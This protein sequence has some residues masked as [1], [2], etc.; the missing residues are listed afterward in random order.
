MKA[1]A[2]LSFLFV[3][4]LFTVSIF[5]QPAEPTLV[6][7]GDG[8]SAIAYPVTI[9]WGDMA[10][11]VTKYKI[12]LSIT[13]GGGAPFLVDQELNY[14][15]D[16]TTD[17]TTITYLPAVVIP[18]NTQVYYQLWSW[19]GVAWSA[20][21]LTYHSFTTRIAQPV[22][23]GP[24]GTA[25]AIHPTAAWTFAGGQTGV[26]FD[27]LYS[28]DGGGT[29]STEISGLAGASVSRVFTHAL[30]YNQ[31]YVVKVTARKGGEAYSNTTSFTTLIA[32]PVITSPNGAGIS[33][34]PTFNWTF[35]G[36]QTG[37]TFDVEYSGDGYV[38]TVSQLGLPGN[39]V[40]QAFFGATLLYNHAYNF[41]ITAHK[42]GDADKVA[43][44][45]FTTLVMPA[46]ALSLPVNA[47]VNQP[48][49][50]TITWAA[51]DGAD[52]YKLSVYSDAACTAELYTT[53]IAG[54]SQQL[55]L[56]T[57]EA[58]TTYYWRVRGVQLGVF[59]NWASAFHFT[60]MPVPISTPINGLTG[61]SVLPTFTWVDKPDET[62][63]TVKVS[64]AGGSQAA[65]DAGVIITKVTLQNAVSYATLA[66]ELNLPL[67]NETMYYWQV[68]VQGGLSNT[69]KSSIYHFTTTPSNVVS[70]S[71]PYDGNVVYGT[72]VNFS[73]FLGLPTNHLQFIVQYKYAAAGPT[74]PEDEAFWSGPTMTTLATTTSLTSPGTILLG[75]T[76]YW[77]VL[78]QR[79]DAPND[80]VYYPMAN[81][82]SSFT[83]AGGATIIVTPS[84]PVG[85][86]TVYT[87]TPTLY[88]YLDMYGSGLVYTVRYSK[89]ADVNGSGML[90][91][92]D[93]V[94]V[95]TSNLYYTFGAALD[96]GVRYYWQLMATYTG[97]NSS[98]AWTTPESFTTQGIGT[99]Q[100]PIPAYPIEGLT[101]YTTSP[102]FHWWLP[103][104]GSGLVYDVDLSTINNF[105][106][107]VAGFPV[108]TLVADQMSYD[109]SGITAGQ[110]YY[111]R[112][113]SRNAANT[114]SAWSEATPVTNAVFTITGGPIWSYAVASWPIGGPIVYTTTPTLN[115]YLEGDN[116]AITGYTVKYKKDSAPANWITYTNGGSVNTDGGVYTVSNATLSQ[117]ITVD[118]PYGATYYWAVYANG[119]THPINALSVGSFTIVGGPAATSVVL[120]E[121]ENLSAFYST[122]PTLYWYLNGSPAGL[123]HYVVR[124]SQSDVFAA[125][126][127]YTVN[128]P[129]SYLP[130]AGLQNGATY[131]WKVLAH[132]TDG[133]TT[134]YSPIWSFSIQEGSA[135]AVQPHIGS[136][137]N[138]TISTI[139]PTLSWVL[140][141]LANTKTKYEI[142]YADNETF[143]NSI[144]ISDLTKTSTVIKGLNTNS[145]YFW[146]VRSK[147]EDGTYSYYS[148]TGRFGVGENVLSVNDKNEIPTQ[149]FISQNYPNP[150]NPSTT[151]K[152]GL[153]SAANVT[154]KVYN[155]VGQEVKTLVSDYR[156][157]GTYRVIW[158]GD[159]NS[160]SKVSSGI[161]IFR[162][163]SGSNSQTMKMILLK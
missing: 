158:N 86:A 67:S 13:P 49:Q 9:Q 29:W 133:R 48:C 17:G 51:V 132:Y 143:Q 148:G 21:P 84:W 122:S 138:V 44:G 52:N 61:V 81:V 71:N 136:P 110:T 58:N 72:P 124:F 4:A 7:P 63:F 90:S 149:F 39:T 93:A 23:T 157:A 121:P 154:I 104:A 14:G 66:T 134:A 35:A 129:T 26:T 57:V 163:V 73:W 109:A 89:H 161:Y 162:V 24:T 16:I 36:G 8:T 12:Q 56:G 10:P 116:V 131:F 135:I 94:N 156:E 115:W 33:R 125:F 34:T 85:N 62:T 69:F 68:S 128:L 43:N 99:V 137:N 3:L 55:P 130:L 103:V 77:R 152:Y 53:T 88:W 38:T 5:A 19:D 76:Y 101:I 142:Q 95:T 151:I 41:R 54:L 11:V 64:T 96:P 6:S 65:F 74:G 91:N 144:T 45:S 20:D 105:A 59:G 2:L 22:V 106:T 126:T 1:K 70:L 25:I 147:S 75:K 153:P 118:L 160:G 100:V 113:R 108:T 60:T 127:D 37:V 18:F 111:W 114:T 83:T 30:L 28:A 98:T 139:A 107:H 87:N 27:V 46:P 120:T 47:A 123:D 117:T 146:R 42:A 140:P 102:S 145:S 82:Y 31:D 92:A 15:V 79:T 112:V 40:S 80:Y 141:V 50:P 159:N 155:M 150:F 78:V 119:A 32:T 97:D